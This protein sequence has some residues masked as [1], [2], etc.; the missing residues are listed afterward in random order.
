M[1]VVFACYGDGSK[2]KPKVI[3]KRKSIPNI[4]NKHGVVVSAQ[5]KGWMNSEHMNVWLKKAWC[6]QLVDLARR[7]SWI[8]FGSF[9]AHMTDPVKHRSFNHENTDLAL[10]PGGLTS[11]LQPPDVCLNKRLKM[12]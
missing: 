1:T 4:N 7:K 5:E 11:L 12:E 2:L 10:I 3:I 8:V 9:V 6:M